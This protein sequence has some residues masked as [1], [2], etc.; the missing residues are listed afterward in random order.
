MN[1]HVFHLHAIA[2]GVDI[3]NCVSLFEI[4]SP[5]DDIH[6]RA[7]YSNYIHIHKEQEIRTLCKSYSIYNPIQINDKR[8]LKTFKN[9]G[10]ENQQNLTE[11]LERR[12]SW[13]SCHS[14]SF[15]NNPIHR[16][17]HVGGDSNN[18][19]KISIPL[20]RQQFSQ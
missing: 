2:N 7:S 13:R 17:I 14:N 8:E 1:L 5:K 3:M 19:W 9:M 4:C 12:G 16:S 18:K 15:Q 6:C 11:E 10:L 20:S